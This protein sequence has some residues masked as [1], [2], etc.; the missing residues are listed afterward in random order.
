M[1]SDVATLQ[2]I[3]NTLKAEPLANQ[4]TLAKNAD[5]SVGLM[6]AVLKR[7]AERGWIMFTHV[8]KQ[9]FAYA[10]TPQGLAELTKRGKNFALRTFRIANTY[11]EAV[12]Q[13]VSG[14]KSEGKTKVVLYGDSYV[15]FL[16]EYA[17]K[18]VDLPLEKRDAPPEN[19]SPSLE[20][21]ALSVSG[22]AC[23]SEA[24]AR[25]I[26]AGCVSL[27]DVLYEKESEMAM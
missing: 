4:R 15:K 8:T 18:E 27:L 12:L 2:N 25:L 24:T 26:S 5:M 1:N 14:A 23:S 7:F 21:N 11:N 6:N 13:L 22:E 10:L 9:K 19:E 16:L 3:A 17:C 20:K